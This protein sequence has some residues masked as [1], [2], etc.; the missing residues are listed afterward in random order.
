[1][2]NEKGLKRAKSIR[3][4]TKVPRKTPA[5]E[6]SPKG[7]VIRGLL[8]H[9][10]AKSIHNSPFP[11]THSILSTHICER[12]ICRA[13]NCDCKEVVYPRAPCVGGDDYAVFVNVGDALNAAVHMADC[14]FKRGSGNTPSKRVGGVRAQGTVKLC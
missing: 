6:F 4:A 3:L 8:R 2:R 1:M 7:G 10:V 9:F 11:I 12:I 5:P 13:I 14:A